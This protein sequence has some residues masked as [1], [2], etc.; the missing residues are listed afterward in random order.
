[1]FPPEFVEYRPWAGKA[2]TEA[3]EKAQDELAPLGRARPS[4]LRKHGQK[5]GA[6]LEDEQ[7][8]E[9]VE[10]KEVVDKV[11]NSAAAVRKELAV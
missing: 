9:A 11:G 6:V 2:R 8:I 1:M 7:L 10:V 4:R 3:V 5:M